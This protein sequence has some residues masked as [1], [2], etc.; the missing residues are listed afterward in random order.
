[1]SD[2]EKSTNENLSTEDAVQLEITELDDLDLAAV[3]GGSED[4][5]NV[6]EAELPATS[7]RGCGANRSCTIVV[8]R[9][10]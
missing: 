3:T 6:G 5:E 10:R 9:P 4:G 7:N 1:M 2:K 8:R